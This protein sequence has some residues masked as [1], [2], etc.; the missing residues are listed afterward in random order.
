MQSTLVINK[1]GKQFFNGLASLY[2]MRV[3]NFNPRGIMRQAG[4][5]QN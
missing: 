2:G 1:C 5:V 3:E 4:A